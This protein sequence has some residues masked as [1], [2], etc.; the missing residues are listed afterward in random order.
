MHVLFVC[1]GN[2]C[3]SPTAE[4]LVQAYAA[5]R[6]LTVTAESAGTRAVV[7]HGVEA[8]ASDVLVSLGGSPDGFAARRLTADIAA[9]ADVIVTMTARHRDGVLAV[10]P[11][12]LR[13]TFT[14]LE[15]S[16]LAARTGSGD[17]AA[18]YRARV[19]APVAALD[20][21]DPIGQ[22]VVVFESIG[23]QISDALGPLLEVWE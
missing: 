17:P 4:R 16:E 1:T 20:I 10:A 14:L 15:A 18:W 2:I 12:K 23:Q 8:T 19:T 13:T 11:R 22:S 3:R 7:G 5:E 6:G 21:D 9:K